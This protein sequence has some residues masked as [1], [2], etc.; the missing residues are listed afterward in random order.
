M[1]KQIIQVNNHQGL[2]LR[3]LVVIAAFSER[4]NRVVLVE[5]HLDDSA[6]T[7]RF[8]ED[9]TDINCEAGN[10]KEHSVEQI[11]LSFYNGIEEEDWQV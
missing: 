7:I 9:T 1:K 3:D 10:Y 2:V 5:E 11:G 6:E 4:T 8:I